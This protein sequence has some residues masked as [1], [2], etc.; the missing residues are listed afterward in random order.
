MYPGYSPGHVEYG[1]AAAEF[2]RYAGEAKR[3]GV[4]IKPEGMDY[5]IGQ[6]K[7][8]SQLTLDKIRAAQAKTNGTGVGSESGGSK[9]STEQNAA[10]VDSTQKAGDDMFFMDSNPTP[11]NLSSTAD[12]SAKRKVRTEPAEAN[13]SK[14]QKRKHSDQATAE[15]GGVEESTGPVNIEFEDISGEVDARLEEKKERRK[16]K[17]QGRDERKRK[18]ESE[19]SAIVTAEASLTADVLKPKKKKLKNREES[20]QAPAAI[21]KKRSATDDEETA[22]ISSAAVAAKK[23]DKKKAKLSQEGT[24]AEKEQKRRSIEDGDGDR[25]VSNRK[26]A[27]ISKDASLEEKQTKGTVKGGVLT[28]TT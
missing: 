5:K 12:S 27:K 3:K 18:R 22:G 4:D 2:G 10:E 15:T 19:G 28:E 7:K 13:P 6:S 11:V 8:L 25:A 16:R 14:K 9:D 23:P 24:T 1:K 21:V 17:Q 20:R 26:K